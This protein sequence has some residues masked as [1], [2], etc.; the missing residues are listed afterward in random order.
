VSSTPIELV[1]SRVQGAKETPA[2]WDALC[3]AHDDHVPSLGIAVTEDGKVLLNCR[4]QGCS[5]AAICKGMG[6]SVSDLFPSK[7][8]QPKMNIVAEY[9]YVDANGQLIYQVVRLDPK[10]FRQRRPDPN[11]KNGWS[12]NLKGVTRVLYHLPKVLK[13]VAE[14]QI[15]FIVEGEKDADNL[16]RKG[17]IATTN[18]GGASKWKREYPE[19]LI[20]AIVVIIPD[21]D[22]PGRQHALKIAKLLHGKAASVKILNLPDLSREGRRVGLV[23]SWRN[24]RTTRSACESHRGIPGYS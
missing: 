5:I 7:N 3:P 8:G 15:I 18:A 9:N 19:S 24:A 23:G 6:I 2:G 10:D 20:G 16:I 13:A 12:W 11:G 14:K 1:L 17:L 21:S 22:Q 4:S